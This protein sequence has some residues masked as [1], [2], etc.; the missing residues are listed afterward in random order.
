MDRK[1]LMEHLSAVCDAEN[2]AY[3]C[4]QAIDFLEEQK[5][6]KSFYESAGIQYQYRIPEP[7]YSGDYEVGQVKELP[8]P[9]LVKGFCAFLGFILAYITRNVFS[10]S[11]IVFPVVG[12]FIGYFIVESY[13]KNEKNTAWDS[14][15]ETNRKR[16]EEYEREKR[17]YE[18][19]KAAWSEEQKKEE[20]HI[21]DSVEQMI[22]ENK[23]TLANIQANLRKLYDMGIVYQRFQ[24]MVAVNTMRE[25]VEMGLCE[26]LEG[27]NGAYAAYLQDL[28]A[29]RICGSIE[30][31][32]KATVNAL[33]QIEFN[34]GLL[35]HEVR[36][37]DGDIKML[38]QS[39]KQN[40]SGLNQKMQGIQRQIRRNESVEAKRWEALTEQMQS[41]GETIK[42]AAYNDYIQ[43]RIESTDRYLLTH[44]RNPL[45]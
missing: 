26:Q 20:L 7:K 28:R 3:A 27:S 8:A 9:G 21:R 1:E 4:K 19:D 25:Y 30:D 40:I 34:Q 37:I 35:I 44:Y 17:K 38:E 22:A 12:W 5:G 45:N 29:E 6:S 18:A 14:I 42:T 23:K 13:N 10:L 24:N 39:L 31:L 2:A 16:R 41:M 33:S 32:K 43:K 36:E 15:Y 11:I